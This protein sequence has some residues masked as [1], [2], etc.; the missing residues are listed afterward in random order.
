MS[1]NSKFN[2]KDDLNISN[3]QPFGRIGFVTIRNRMKKQFTKRYFKAIMVGIPRHHSYGN[4]YM[5][6]PET[7]WIIISRDIRWAPFEK[8]TFYDELEEILILQTEKDATII[9]YDS[10]SNCS[11]ENDQEDNLNHLG[12]SEPDIESNNTEESIEENT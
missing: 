8:P 12:G 5:Y 9:T 10:K 4:Y 3:M 1:P 2:N 7:K 6:N 11:D